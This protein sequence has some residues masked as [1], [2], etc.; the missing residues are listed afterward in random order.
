M[1][2]GELEIE[3]DCLSWRSAKRWQ[4]CHLSAPVQLLQDSFSKAIK[5]RQLHSLTGNSSQYISSESEHARAA[6]TTAHPSSLALASL[7]HTLVFPSASRITT[8][9]FS[10]NSYLDFFTLFLH[11][12]CIFNNEDVAFVHFVVSSV[13][14][15]VLVSLGTQIHA[16]QTRNEASKLAKEDEWG[17]RGRDLKKW[18][19]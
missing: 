8:C 2:L 19:N 5:Q 4:I 18:I 9:E 15:P 3:E 6:L 14:Q 11:L 12:L 10:V 7:P 13:P 16:T 1:S 17:Q